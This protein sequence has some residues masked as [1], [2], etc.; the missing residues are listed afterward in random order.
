M[1]KISI[2]R[3]RTDGQQE[4]KE[5]MFVAMNRISCSEEYIDRFEKLFKDRAREVDNLEGFISAK[6][7]RPL[8]D[9]QPYV[10]MTYWE[11]QE[12]FDAWLKTDAFIKGHARG[13]DDMKKAR[14]EGR[15]PPMTSTMEIY[16]VFAD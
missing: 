11:A 13:F 2:V 1:K 3:S 14:E 15:K 10:V 8:K 9:D 5:I 7:L 4:K 16:E 12:Y 6:I